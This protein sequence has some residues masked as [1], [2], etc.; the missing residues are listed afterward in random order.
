MAE[1]LKYHF[2]PRTGWINDPNGL[3]F[4][5]GK[6][7]AF[8]QHYPFAPRWGQMHWGHAVSEDL[9]HWEELPIALYPDRE[10]EDSKQ[11]GCFSGCAVVKD[12]V[13][14][15]IY[16]SVSDRHGQTQSV[17]M[18]R[19][20]VRFD[21]YDGNPVIG[22]FPAEASA[23]FRDPKVTYMNG[24]YYMV[25]ASGKDG[26]GKILLYKSQNLLEWDYEGVLFEGAQFGGIL[27]CPD[28]FPF[29][30][31]YLLMF[32]QMNCDT[33][34]TMFAYGDF[35]G[36]KLT[37]YS[38]HTPH[39][40]PHYYAPQTF[41]DHRGRRILIGWLF[42]KDEKLNGGTDYAGAL[43][44][45]CELSMKDGK[46]RAYPVEEAQGLLSGSDELVV[47]EDDKI[48]I[49]ADNVAF[50]VEYSARI[51]SVRVL[52]DTKTIEVFVNEGE[53]VFTYW[54]QNG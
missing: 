5:Q 19:D 50:P 1:R 4:F 20:G 53:A 40:G 38:L 23:D 51:D 31:K 43:T 7:H 30:D 21:K 48:R 37:N 39:I 32:S 27:E 49:K 2:E 44:I 47:V 24:A 11:G 18:S 3:V 29:K 41:E 45:P 26:I 34:S 28:F 12:D 42:N 22:S 9:V 25:V 15:L 13:L 6:Y 14:Y 52:R 36:K 16:S 17:A 54:Y 10:Y 46:L 35:D 33:R 8:F